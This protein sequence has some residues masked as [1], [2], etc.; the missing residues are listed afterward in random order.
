MASA[1][2]PL[3]KPL[4]LAGYVLV[5][6]CALLCLGLV[7]LSGVGLVTLLL[8]SSMV[9]ASAAT[10]GVVVLL[11]ARQRTAETEDRTTASETLSALLG[12]IESG[13]ILVDQ[14]GHI[15]LFNAAAEIVFGRLSEET[16]STPVQLLVPDLSEQGVLLAGPGED[17]QTPR[18]RHLSGLRAGDEF[19]LR[20]LMRD[21]KL[22]GENWLLI[23]VEDLAETERVETQLDF[24][25][26]HDPLTGLGNRRALERAVAASAAQPALA[27]ISHTLCLVDLDHFKVINSAC[28]HAAGDELLQQVASILSTR[29]S[30]ATVLARLGA[31]EFGALFVGVNSPIVELRCQE[32]VRTLRSFLFT[33]QD[34]SYDLSAS[35][36]LVTFT[37]EDGVGDVLAQADMACQSAKSLG[38]NRAHRYSAEDALSIR[39]HAELAL[40]SSIGGALDGGRFHI[41][42]QPI[43]PLRGVDAPVHYEILVRMSDDQG[44]PVAPDHFV[45]AA[46][47]YI[48]MPT[49]DRWILSHLLEHE[50]GTL[51]AWHSQYPDRFMYAVNLSATTLMDEGF[52][53]FLKRQFKD[54]R[55]PYQ[56][57]CFEITE[58]AA[59]SDLGRARVFMDTLVQLGSSFAVDDFG[60]G[61][62]S[63][64]Y[65]K[66]LPLH[67]LKIDGSFVRHLESDPVD[68][69]LVE[70]IN[71]LAHVLGLETIAEW[72]ETPALIEALRT[73]GVDYVQGY[74]VGEPM[75][76]EELRLH[77]AH[78]S[79]GPGW[80][81][82]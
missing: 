68:R 27:N 82:N 61:F 60:A 11:R 71:R 32:L 17:P 41:M 56:S 35:V 24:L 67:Y 20:L 63:Y 72:A 50:A 77:R 31:D 7:F 48:L 55:V 57:I 16:L 34:H 18:V 40:I 49:L 13:V 78:G 66:S 45:P 65:L 4:I 30:D 44:N 2:E 1:R 25:S 51:R 64:A 70:S 33:W 42:A 8:L 3:A 14:S 37:P 75:S 69:A 53:T 79:A 29:F 15:R 47:R 76:L 36:G 43:L 22:D 52:L 59:V 81:V 28:G 10:L 6:L 39:R 74:G 62:G 26:R 38:G 12:I 19:P 5:G 46:E 21:L 58:T 73:M 54:Y 9:L 23:L 80:D